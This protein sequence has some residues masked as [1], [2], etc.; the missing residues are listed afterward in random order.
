V[1]RRV[2]LIGE[3]V[4]R[5]YLYDPEFTPALALEKIV[6]PHF[7][8]DGIEVI[9]LAR[10]NLGYKVRELAI[11]ALPLEPD[12]AI[13]FAGNNW[14]TSSPGLPRLRKIDE[15]LSKKGLPERNGSVRHRSNEMRGAS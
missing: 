8:D 9:D 13:I 15:A 12:M 7:G 3:S 10:T 6:E 14:N 1:K 2:L 5:G 4:A 11:A